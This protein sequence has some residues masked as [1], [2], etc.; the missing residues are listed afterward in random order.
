MNS[1][2]APTFAERLAKMPT[3]TLSVRL[4]LARKARYLADT[5]Y[6]REKAQRDIDALKAELERRGHLVAG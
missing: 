1:T 4:D 3:G 5:T 6:Q 2:P